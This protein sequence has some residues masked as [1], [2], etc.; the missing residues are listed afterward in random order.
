VVF[1]DGQNVHQDFRRAFVVD[2]AIAHPRVGSFNPRK[3]SQLLVARGPDFEEWTLEAV[4]VYVGSPVAEH[5]PAAAAAHDRQ[6]E[7]WR[8]WGVVPVPRPLSYFDWPAQAPRQ[9]GVDAA[10]AVDIVRMAVGNEYE[11]GIVL[12]TDTD[13]LPAIEAVSG[14]RGTNATPRICTVRYGDLGKRLY[15]SDHLG[16]SM[17]AFHLTAEDFAAVRDDTNYATPSPMGLF[18][19]DP[20]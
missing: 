3:L 15:H 11:I 8:V 14:L 2:P 4:R 9:K 13:L 1:V 10:M 17:H 6:M 16:R 18:P 12:S 19:P 7:Q 20:T 5:Q